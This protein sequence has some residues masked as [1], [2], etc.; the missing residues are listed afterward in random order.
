MKIAKDPQRL[1]KIAK[2]CQ[3]L[4]KIAKDRQRLQKIAKDHQRLPKIA[5]GLKIQDDPQWS[6]KLSTMDQNDYKVV[7]NDPK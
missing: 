6:T 7:H 5:K 2:D 1:P 4:P 3:R